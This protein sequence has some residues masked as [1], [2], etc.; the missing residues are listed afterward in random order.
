MNE[1]RPDQHFWFRGAWFWVGP[2]MIHI[3]EVPNPDPKEGRPEH[4]G[5]D[6]HVCLGIE[7]LEPLIAKLEQARVTF[8]RAV[9]G[10]RA[11]FF[12]DP[13]ANT[14][15]VFETKNWM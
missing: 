10:R 1:A 7:Q 13:D 3:M 12:R 4:G 8:T 15:E 5:E 14:I 2:N 6:R 11:I 9:N